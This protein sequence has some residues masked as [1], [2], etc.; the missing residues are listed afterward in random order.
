MNNYTIIANNTQLDT[1]NNFSISLNYEIENILSL[2]KRS[3]S[4]TKTIILPSTPTNDLFFN[5]IFDVN[6]NL[7]SFNPTKSIPAVIRSN[8]MQLFSGSL[9]LVNVN[10]DHKVVTYEVTIFG[11]L[12]DL[13]GILSTK[14]LSDLDLER[15][16]HIRDRQTIINSFTYGIYENGLYTEYLRGG[17]GYV[18]P[19]IVYGLTTNFEHNFYLKDLYP[20]VYD[21]TIIKQMM[22]EAGYNIKSNWLESDYA[23][24]LIYPFVNDKLQLTEE[25]VY[26]RGIAIGVNEGDEYVDALPKIYG[27]S[28][29]TSN[30]YMLNGWTRESGTVDDTSGEI[31]FKDPSGQFSNVFTCAET[32]YY[33]INFEGKLF[34]KY[35]RDGGGDIKYN[36]GSGQ[37]EYF[38]SMERVSVDGTV[39]SIAGSTT[40]TAPSGTVLFSPSDGLTHSSPWIDTATP[41]TTSMA[42]SNILLEEGDIIRIRYEARYPSG[43]NWVGGGSSSNI[44]MRLVFKQVVVDDFSKFVIEPSSNESLGY[45][46][47]SMKQ[48][49]PN[50]IKCSDY[51][52]D[53]I[54]EFNLIVVEDSEDPTTLI[55]E[56][57]DDY[58]TNSQKVLNWD[59]ENH[60]D[61][62]KLDYDSGYKL[63]PMSELDATTYKFTYTEDS[64]YYNEQY[65][66]ETK[67]V[68]GEKIIE[69]ENDFSN[70]TNEI[71][72]GL[73]P[74]VDSSEFIDGRVAPF[75]VTKDDEN[76]QQMK[77]KPR[78][79]F[80]GGMINQSYIIIQ[81][82]PG[83][84]D[85][86][87]VQGYPYC[88]MWDNP[89][90][91]MY[92]LE[93]GNSDKLYWDTNQTPVKTLYEMYY[94]NTISNLI[95]PN[96]K[97]FEG[98]FW[99]TEKDIAE[100][101]FR[102]IVFLQ[103]Q[104][105]RVDSI[106][107][108]DPVNSNKLTTVVLYSL[109]EV[110][111]INPLQVNVPT[112]NKSCPLDLVMK[113]QG[114][115]WIQV[116]ASGQ[117]VTKDCCDSLGGDFMGGL[118]YVGNR[119]P[120]DGVLT[121]LVSP[122]SDPTGP[123]KVRDGNV[124]LSNGVKVNGT[125]NFVPAGVPPTVQ[126]MGDGNTI[127]PGIKNVIVIGDSVTATQSNGININGTFIGDNGIIT[128]NFNML[129]GPKDTVRNLFP[130]YPL[131]NVWKS[132]T[133]AVRDVDFTSIIN[134]I[135][136][137]RD[138][139]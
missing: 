54:K 78:R 103:G 23:S 120:V 137:G 19:H 6:I 56:P 71:K 35:E 134:I 14:F 46:E 70:K 76:F 114:K 73:A 67:K 34:A 89:K 37:F 26:Q 5:N 33:K 42:V 2:D 95:N 13:M 90:N 53:L 121:P 115:R 39:I 117:P 136:G 59:D 52:M 94:K 41:L 118:C 44:G 102:N 65:T 31:T 68:F 48:I 119:K 16:N 43:V 110:D 25:Q 75:F 8:D 64:D 100:F 66:R 51:F 133:N 132:G 9:Q 113:R 74:T 77:V 45:E 27:G 139:V 20:A 99:L 126:I 88:G 116:S 15:Y 21:K 85:F 123:I 135:I 96:S 10:V 36:V 57:R 105:W 17:E 128:P 109:N 79:L 104:Y 93:F 29:W 30:G 92:S 3:T 138:S 58:Y 63:T 87:V 107:D 84:E 24:K 98:E 86:D 101:D 125:K 108:F 62:R 47:I 60:P 1:T 82:F 7:T 4:W 127:V 12:S 61:G 32:G 22:K 50:N 91:P 11:A 55:I 97:L 18:Y 40:S 124:I 69:V 111:Y 72:V 130:Q 83:S 28:N 81:D 49:L 106:K 112:S 129:T 80:Y 122:I 38:Y 131:V